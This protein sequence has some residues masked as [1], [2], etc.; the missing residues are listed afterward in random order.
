MNVYAFVGLLILAYASCAFIVLVVGLI[1]KSRWISI[2]GGIAL[3]LWLVIIVKIT[4]HH[5]K[6]PAWV[7]EKE[8]LTPPPRGVTA[9][10]GNATSMDNGGFVY[11]SFSAPPEV[12]GGLVSDRMDAASPS[13]VP[14]RKP[15]SY[16]DRPPV[17]WDPPAVPP[18]KLYRARRVGVSKCRNRAR[19]SYSRFLTRSDSPGP[20]SHLGNSSDQLGS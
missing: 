2:V 20:G 17:W 4:E 8:F 15:L 16:R 19:Y 14:L 11:L 18:A 6:D 9:L 1:L 12:I 10:R 3:V 7:F 13:D 5:S